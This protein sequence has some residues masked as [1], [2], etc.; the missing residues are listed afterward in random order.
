MSAQEKLLRRIAIHDPACV[1]DVLRGD[2]AEAALD[3]RTLALVRLA[4]LIAVDAPEA[5]LSWGVSEAIGAGATPSEVTGVL[6]AVGPAIGSARL[7]AEAPR[8]GRALGWDIDA[9]LEQL[10]QP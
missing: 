9:A 4:G 6:V 8:L 7:V 10:D 3:P 1:E 2:S 5:A